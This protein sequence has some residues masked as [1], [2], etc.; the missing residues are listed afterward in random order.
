MGTSE[1]M[2]FP[3]RMRMTSWKLSSGFTADDRKAMGS[4]PVRQPRAE[5][6]QD[7]SILCWA[8]LGRLFPA[9]DICLSQPHI[10]LFVHPSSALLSRRVGQIGM[11]W[12]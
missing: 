2:S 1:G 6:E 11:K 7:L 9:V 4:R 8:G 10:C 12:C 5:A 3:L